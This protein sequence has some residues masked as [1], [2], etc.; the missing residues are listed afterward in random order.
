MMKKLIFLGLSVIYMLI[1][2]FC[3]Y[4]PDV[5][6]HI[7][8]EENYVKIDATVISA[9]YNE[10]GYSYIYVTLSDFYYYEDFFG[11]EPPDYSDS[12]LL[13]SVLE[14]KL[15]TA[16]AEILKENG[17][18]DTVKEGDKIT[19]M[20]TAWV[21]KSLPHHYP[22]YVALGDTV[23]LTFTEGFNNI[24]DAATTLKELDYDKILNQK[25]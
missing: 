2:T 24:S 3:E 4:T 12:T 6:N 13:S 8:N 17:F 19:V 9:K 25:D 14:L 11:S 22:A 20:T 18:F 10:S 7:T 1:M 16:N 15:V 5:I 21:N 23:Y